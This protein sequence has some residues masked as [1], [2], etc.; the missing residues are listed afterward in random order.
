M[1][2]RFCVIAGVDGGCHL[3]HPL[4]HIL[5]LKISVTESNSYIDISHADF[6]QLSPYD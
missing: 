5:C 6:R 3:A 4:G 1:L 2:K